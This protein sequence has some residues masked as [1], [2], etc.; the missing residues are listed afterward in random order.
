[1]LKRLIN[2]GITDQLDSFDKRGVRLT[3]AIV[4]SIIIF[5]ILVE[6]YTLI[7]IGVIPTGVIQ[8]FFS[9]A[10]LSLILLL[11]YLHKYKLARITLLIQSN[12]SLIA[13]ILLVDNK[14]GA[15]EFHYLNFILY[16]VILREY[17][18]IY[19]WS[20]LTIALYVSGVFLE[21]RGYI[22]PIIVFPEHQYLL[23][24]PILFIIA[25]ISIILVLIFFRKENENKENQLSRKIKYNETLLKEVH[26]RV[27]NNLQLILSL[28]EL[29]MDKDIDKN[30]REVLLECQNRVYAMYLVHN[31][32]IS[33]EERISLS[34]YIT[35]LYQNIK[36]SFPLQNIDYLLNL[37]ED[38]YCDLNKTLL[39][40][41]II[42]ELITNS[43]KHAFEQKQAD[44]LIEITL[45]K[46]HNKIKLVIKD[47]GKG[48]H[49]NNK[50]DDHNT[51]GLKLVYMIAKQLKA[52]IETENKNG[53]KVVVVF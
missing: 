42:N 5:A 44:K 28:L 4:F 48:N 39:L 15:S 24:R 41:I 21:Y 3:N 46:E 17:W 53:F 43:Y 45:R 12:L 9:V 37:E 51:L 52:K 11:N 1:M 7:V 14:I 13:A 31:R 6:I 2:I 10:L 29:Q 49:S 33:G 30:S 34:D 47:N 32:L 40:G 38:L 20:I 22:H 16:V 25:T 50:T 19:F 23:F 18:K 27:K 35:D 36:K 26:H 8:L